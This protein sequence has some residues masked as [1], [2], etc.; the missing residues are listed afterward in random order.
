[1]LP[2]NDANS[3]NGAQCVTQFPRGTASAD[4]CH[5]QANVAEEKEIVIVERIFG[6]LRLEQYLN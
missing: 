2:E 4:F 5:T 3:K 1:M 6:K